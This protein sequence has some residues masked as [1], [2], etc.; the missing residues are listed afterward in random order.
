VTIG[1]VVIN[2][3][4]VN[5]GCFCVDGSSSPTAVAARKKTS[6]G[7]QN[8]ECFGLDD[9]RLNATVSRSG[10]RSVAARPLLGP[11][12]L[13]R[14]NHGSIVRG[15]VAPHVAA[16]VSVSTTEAAA[17]IAAQTITS[18]GVAFALAAWGAARIHGE[19]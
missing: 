16:A 19:L 13:K 10:I 3:H 1:F 18:L 6:E 12:R 8:L 15:A 7:F 2:D 14:R 11:S 5:A 9:D 17:V 4:S